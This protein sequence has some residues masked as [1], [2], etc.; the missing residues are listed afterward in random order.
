[1][2]HYVLALVVQNVDSAICRINVYPVDNTIGLR[3]TYRL[4][5]HLPDVKHHSKFEQPRPGLTRRSWYHGHQPEVLLQH[6]FKTRV[7]RLK[8]E[9]QKHENEHS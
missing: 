6:D 2:A 1:M 9:V 7:L 3:N 5:S 8:P 4:D